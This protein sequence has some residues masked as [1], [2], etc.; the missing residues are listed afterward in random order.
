MPLII[1]ILLVTYGYCQEK[2]DVGHRWDLKGYLFSWSYQSFVFPDPTG[3]APQFNLTT[4]SSLT[5]SFINWTEVYWAIF[6]KRPE[7]MQIYWDRRRS[8]VAKEFN[9]HGIGPVH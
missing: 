1:I 5:D 2:I 9:F 4:I 8:Y 6:L 3:E 7:L